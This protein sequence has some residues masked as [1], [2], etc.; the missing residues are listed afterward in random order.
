MT[1]LL[2]G[3]ISWLISRRSTSLESTY[4]MYTGV[5]YPIYSIIQDD[6]DGFIREGKDYHIP[7]EVFNEKLLE[8]KCILANSRGAHSLYTHEIVNSL[9]VDD[10]DNFCFYIDKNQQKCRKIL[11]IREPFPYMG[12][13]L[14][15]ARAAAIIALIVTMPS[16]FGLYYY[17]WH[18]S[19]YGMAICA[20]ILLLAML[21]LFITR[22]SY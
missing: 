1:V 16:Y 18:N 4:R 19:S 22:K 20:G 21:T 8:I 13:Q 11:N 2:S 15:R 10:Y 9:N 3:V 14:N 7:I 12:K 17:S 5:I 6:I